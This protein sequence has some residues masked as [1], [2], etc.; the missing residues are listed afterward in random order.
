MKKKK[1]LLQQQITV[2][3]FVAKHAVKNG[4][5]FHMDR[6]RDSK[7]GKCKHALL[8]TQDIN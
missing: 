1:Q 6:K 5:G 7:N 8:K 4:A 3:N 2:R